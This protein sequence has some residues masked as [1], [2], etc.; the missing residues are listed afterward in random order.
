MLICRKSLL[1][2]LALSPSMALASAGPAAHPFEACLIGEA[3]ALEPSGRQVS[4]VLADAEQA[5][6]KAKGE[7]GHAAIEEIA[8]KA[9]LAVIQQ[10]SNARNTTRRL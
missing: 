4:Q 8:S 2:L 10:R 7:L 1:I 9:R 3:L 5:C 6:R